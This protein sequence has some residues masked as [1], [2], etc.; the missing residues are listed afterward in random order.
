MEDT[1]KTAD[2]AAAAVFIVPSARGWK[3]V[4]S[5]DRNGTWDVRELQSLAEVAPL[6]NASEDFVLG[7]P[8]SA[9]LAQRLKLPNVEPEEFAEMVRIQ[10]EK[11]LPFSTDEVTTDFEVIEQDENG[12]IVS[13]IAVQNQKL[14]EIA[15]PLLDRG[16]IPTQ[17]TV[18]AAQRAATHAAE[19]LSLLIYPEGEQL[20]SAISENGKLS[21]TRTM[22][23]ME[24]AQLEM[25]LPQL[26]LS[27]E[28]QGIETSFPNV[29][30]DESCYEM[31]DAVQ[32]ILSS[33]TDLVGIE[34]PPA[35]TRLNL[36][37][38]SW[39]Q[40]RTQLARRGEWK[41]RLI[42]AGAVYAS[43]VLLTLAYVG[44]LRFRLASEERRIARDAPQT[45]F[46]RQMDATWKA[47]APAVDPRHY[48]IEV[49]LHLNECIPSEDVRITVYNQSA[50]QVSIDGESKSAALAYQFAD[51][52][53][54]HPELQN[55]QFDMAAPRILPNDHAQFRLEGKPK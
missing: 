11:A 14:S 23:G 8:V 4:R 32:E 47:L 48:P 33:R 31:R 45:E 10:V 16:H 46:V 22:D 44:F 26:A 53:K 2:K 36:L 1:V 6:L 43:L 49:L 34:K 17:V 50:R 29:F 21:I 30:L 38:A 39:R 12:S 19:G 42:W 37:P 3:L 25:E 54:K 27:A 18:Y 24:P 55:F 41:K 9:I 15:A 35:F 52:V 51:R 40:R 7:L 28:L 13:A 20:V 5:A